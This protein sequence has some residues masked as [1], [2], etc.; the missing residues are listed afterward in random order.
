MSSGA[1]TPAM[2]V[3]VECTRCGARG[4]VPY[5]QAER[6]TMAENERTGRWTVRLWCQICRRGH[7]H[8]ARVIL[9]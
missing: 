7:E 4:R 3:A 2:A 6:A 1:G 8:R 5:R 9:P